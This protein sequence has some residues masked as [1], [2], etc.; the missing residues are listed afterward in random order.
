MQ[1]WDLYCEAGAWSVDLA[2]AADIYC[3]SVPTTAS[4]GGYT[5]LST[6]WPTQESTSSSATSAT[7][8]TTTTTETEPSP[9]STTTTSTSP[10]LT[11]SSPDPDCDALCEDVEDAFLTEGCCTP[12]Y[13]MCASG[14]GYPMTCPDDGTLFCGEQQTCVY[15]CLENPECCKEESTSTSTSSGP[16]CA[17]FCAGQD[18]GTVGDCCAQEYCDCNDNSLVTC[19]GD[20]QYCPAVWDGCHSMY[21]AC[22]SACC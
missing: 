6:Y 20:E 21:G 2:S 11:T 3:Y 13:C 4:T 19:S 18:S 12:K 8:T 15:E 5:E 14:M 9:V 10:P 1:V 16:D 17:S 7:T 22:L